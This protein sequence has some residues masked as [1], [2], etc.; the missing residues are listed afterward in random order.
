M[1]PGKAMAQAAHAANDFIARW[2]HLPT[3]KEDWCDKDCNFGTT[4]VLSVDKDTLTEVIK[5]AQMRDGSVPF[6]VV[7]DKMY[8]F[9]V[10]K[11]VS[12]LISPEK[13]TADNI[14]KDNGQVVMFRKELTCGYVFVCEDSSD[15]K[16]LVGSLLL[17]P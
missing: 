1:N 16:D 7:W 12:S 13:L 10:T 15:Q 9:M 14:Y 8:P 3:V 17:Y 6:G 5:R 4:I 11:E 2:G